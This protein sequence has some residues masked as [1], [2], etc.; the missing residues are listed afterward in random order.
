[1]SAKTGCIIGAFVGVGVAI[2]LLSLEHLRPFSPHTNAAIEILTFR[3]CPLY[4]LGFA[5]G[6]G[7]MSALMAVTVLGNAVLYGA[8][9]CLLGALVRLMRVKKLPE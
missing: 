8:A 5:K 6:M 9:A 3:L 4:I 2:I 1:M 7:S